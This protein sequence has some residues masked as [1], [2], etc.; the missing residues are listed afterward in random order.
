MPAA[1]AT[2]GLLLLYA[3]SSSTYNSDHKGPL[4]T[5]WCLLGSFRII[6]FINNYAYISYN[7]GIPFALLCLLWVYLHENRLFGYLS[8][9]S[10]CLCFPPSQ[11]HMFSMLQSHPQPSADLWTV[12]RDTSRKRYTSKKTLWSYWKLF[13]F[14]NFFCGGFYLGIQSWTEI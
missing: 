7:F 9:E 2:C 6:Q 12:V 8:S 4:K 5:C 13:C 11:N 3:T 10:F 14:S 1:V